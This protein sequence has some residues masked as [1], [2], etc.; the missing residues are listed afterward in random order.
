MSSPLPE[1]IFCDYLL[2]PS[3]ALYPYMLELQKNPDAV[4][5]EIKSKTPKLPRVEWSSRVGNGDGKIVFPEGTVVSGSFKNFRLMEG[6]IEF[7]TGVRFKGRFRMQDNVMVDLF[8][9]GTITFED[10]TY[11]KVDFEN[12]KLRK[13]EI[14]ERNNS[15]LGRLTENEILIV[16]PR[17]S[18]IPKRMDLLTFTEEKLNSKASEIDVVTYSYFGLFLQKELPA[19]TEPQFFK[20]NPGLVKWGGVEADMTKAEMDYISRC[21]NDD[22]SILKFE[23][24]NFPG[25][26]LLFVDD[27]N[28]PTCGSGFYSMKDFA[29]RVTLLPPAVGTGADG[30]S[31]F[32]VRNRAYNLQNLKILL[33]QMLDDQVTQKL[34]S[35]EF[36]FMEQTQFQNPNEIDSQQILNKMVRKYENLQKQVDA[37]RTEHRSKISHLVNINNVLQK[38]NEELIASELDARNIKKKLETDNSSLQSEMQL[39]LKE[40]SV[41]KS[42][43]A[44]E[45]ERQRLQIGELQTNLHRLNAD[46][47]GLKMSTKAKIELLMNERTEAQNRTKK[48][49]AEIAPLVA[50]IEKMKATLVNA[51]QE[52][53]TVLSQRVELEKLVKEREQREKEAK[54]A[55]DVTQK[56]LTKTE[57]RLKSSED[58]ASALE[59]ELGG[60]RAKYDSVLEERP[61]FFSGEM[62]D[63]KKVGKCILENKFGRWEGNFVNDWMTDGKLTNTRT[64]KTLQGTTWTNGVYTGKD[65]K[66]GAVNYIGPIVLNTF[67]G[68]GYLDFAND[69][70]LQASFENDEIVDKGD[71]LLVNLEDGSETKVKLSPDKQTLVGENGKKWIID[72]KSG[73]IESADV[74]K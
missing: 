3:N 73:R 34:S 11:V 39:V 72:Y 16:R 64:M 23:I 59:R 45:A 13:V 25:R 27:S 63:G 51:K 58:K 24:Q 10:G 49:E 44:K 12:L 15:S 4:H 54:G 28:K 68:R 57:D 35:S 33:R 40:V 65:A 42:T 20:N 32:L 69:Y 18:L 8:Q 62:R 37:M 48:K 61:I 9:S 14:F 56:Q 17:L 19:A 22:D 41:V 21:K 55:L 74:R 66:I 47:E 6:M 43:A 46:Y 5:R 67:K 7:P 26:F 53:I 31:M 71:M 60:I 70:N 36:L 52:L 2:E 29:E 1:K 38:K 50:E 30:P